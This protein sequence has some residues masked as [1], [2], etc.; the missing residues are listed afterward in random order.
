MLFLLVE[1]LLGFP[2]ILF[3]SSYFPPPPTLPPLHQP[4]VYIVPLVDGFAATVNCFHKILRV[5]WQLPSPVT[6]RGIITNFI[7]YVSGELT[8]E[9]LH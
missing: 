3:L 8:F 7:V 2:L 1:F 9:S 6:S 5:S 4:A